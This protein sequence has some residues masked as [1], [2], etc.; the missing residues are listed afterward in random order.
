MFN[1]GYLPG[2]NNKALTTKRETTLP[3]VKDALERTV[4]HTGEI[5]GNSEIECGNYRTLSLALAKREAERY[6]AILN[7]KETWSF[8]YE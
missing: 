4:A 1:L 5:F 6:L 2:S 3:A 7:E 8:C